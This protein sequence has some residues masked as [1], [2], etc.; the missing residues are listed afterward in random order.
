VEAVEKLLTEGMLPRDAVEAVL[1][2]A[3]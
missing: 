2:A 1:E 3:V